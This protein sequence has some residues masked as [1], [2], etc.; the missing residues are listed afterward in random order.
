MS[1]VPDELMAR[2]QRGERRA[3]AEILTRIDNG[4]CPAAPHSA[5]QP[6]CVGITGSGGAGKSTLV[7]ALVHYLRHAGKRVAVLA[8]DPQS[9]RS[10]GALLGDRVRTQF[11]PADEGVY[12]RSFSTRGAPGGIS[13]AIEPAIAWLAAFGFDVVLVETV[14]VG[15]DQQAA[16]PLVDRLVLLVTPNT[17][18]EVQWEKAGVIEVADVVAVNKAD[19]PGAQRVAQQLIHTLSLDRPKRDVPVVLVTAAK[20]EGVEELW[21]K[22]EQGIAEF[23]L[24]IA[25]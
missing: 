18:D 16:R 7:N 11:D 9:A 14:G 17:G 4:Q 10:G 13:Q 2:F 25:K 3:L 19:L 12:F 1:E 20:G 5:A 23:G 6:L 8:C 21:R 15:Q 22:I 24:R